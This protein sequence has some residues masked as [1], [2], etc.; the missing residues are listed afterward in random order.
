MTLSRRAVIAAALA[1]TLTPLTWAQTPTRLTLK[2]GAPLPAIGMGTWITFNIAPKGPLAPSR[3]KVLDAFFAAGGSMIDS[4]PMYGRAEDVVG[5]LM[6]GRDK[7]SLF[8]ATKI[9]TP[10]ASNGGNQLTDSHRLWNEPQLDLVYVHNLLRWKAH[11]KTLRAA[12]DA[13]QVRYIGLTTSHGRRHDELERLIKS[14]NIDAVQFTYNV[15]HREAENRLLPAA[16]DKGLAVIIN[17]PLDGGNL[18]NRVKGHPLPDWAS[19]IEC[20]SWSEIFLKFI[21]S[22]PA[23]TCAIP[24]TSQ[25][26]HMRENMRAL[27]GPMPDAKLRQRIIAYVEGL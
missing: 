18:F 15:K 12:K 3:E 20:Q 8:S 17:R 23:V 13:G 9:W 10:L 27:N 1:T 2:S 4:S 19:K 11:L 16:R 24:A 22:H 5:K 6:A 25:P 14:E 21:I 26:T 7:T